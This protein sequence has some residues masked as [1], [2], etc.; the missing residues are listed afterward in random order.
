M[1]HAGCVLLPAFA[2]LGHECQD[3]WSPCDGM[4]V[5]IDHTSVYTLLQKSFAGMESEPMLTPSENSPLLEQFFS[6]E[7]RTQDTASSRTASLTR[8]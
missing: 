8:Y 4:H 2:R 6:E 3:L 5:S 1:V 7:D